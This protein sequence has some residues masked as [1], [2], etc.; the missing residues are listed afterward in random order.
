MKYKTRENKDATFFVTEK[1]EMD[2]CTTAFLFGRDKVTNIV[3]GSE[4]FKDNKIWNKK[5][6]K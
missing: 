2:R 5:R 4:R 3:S 6:W 1:E